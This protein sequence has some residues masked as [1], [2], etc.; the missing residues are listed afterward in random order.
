MRSVYPLINLRMPE[1]IFM[2]LGMHV[3]E[4][5]PIPTGVFYKSHQSMCTSFRCLATV[6]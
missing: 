5:E 2:K 4:P 3:M 6:R 1:P